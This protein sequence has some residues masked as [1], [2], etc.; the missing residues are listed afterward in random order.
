MCPSRGHHDDQLALWQTTIRTQTTGSAQICTLTCFVSPG[1][2]STGYS[3]FS[4]FWPGEGGGGSYSFS[5][6]TV[7]VSVH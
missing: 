2:I 3:F 5:I 4:Q 1:G 6:S 7:N